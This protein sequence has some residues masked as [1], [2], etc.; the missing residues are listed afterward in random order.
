MSDLEFAK[1]DPL[2]FLGVSRAAEESPA[3]LQQLSAG[4]DSKRLPGISL[5]VEGSS[6]I[7]PYSMEN[8]P[9]GMQSIVADM[10]PAT[11]SDFV[12]SDL[13]PVLVEASDI[14]AV[15]AHVTDLGGSAEQI[16]KTVLRARIPRRRLAEMAED[17]A[18]T[19]I[20]SSRELESHCDLAHGSSRL[21]QARANG[22]PSQGEGVLIGIVDT[23]IDT[24]H[25]AFKKGG[26]TR[27]VRYIDQEQGVEYSRNDI[28]NGLAAASPD[29]VGHGTHVAGICAGN[30]AGSSKA[31]YAGVAPQA[32]I[33][34]VKTT[35][36][37][38]DVALGVKQIFD[39]ADELNQPCVVNLS[40]GGHFGAHDGTSVHERAIDA[41]S[42][43]GRLVV[44][45]A[46]N[47]GRSDLHAGT[48]LA[49]GNVTPVRWVADFELRPRI[50][51]NTLLGL[52]AVQVWHQHEDDI[53]IRLRS[54]NGEFFE[55]P[56]GGEKQFDRGVFVA[57]C[58]HQRAAHSQDHATTFQVI[59]SAQ[60]QWLT[61]WSVVVEE[62]RDNG[63]QGVQVG[64]VHAWILRRDMGRFTRGQT[65][66][67]LI[68]M[69]GT[70]FSAITVASYGTRNGWKSADPNQPDVSLDAVNVE[71]ISYFSSP[72]PSRDGDTKPEIA[73]PGQWLI[74]ALSSKATTEEIPKWLRSP[75]GKYTAMQGTSMSAP[76]TAGALALLLENEPTIDPGEAK[77]RLIKSARQD[78]FTAPCWNQRWGYGKLNIERLLQME[79]IW[80]PA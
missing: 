5:M 22:L 54:P 23:G 56:Q 38:D 60:P 49:S 70:A 69:P 57:T 39:V 13:V 26:Q 11:A 59:A 6:V 36:N 44:V 68:G 77:R 10:A 66:S 15:S 45:S 20:E 32:D 47:E 19:Y 40:L 80:H 78:S 76:Y 65:R 24:D 42:G 34:M 74:S 52:L 63:R 14:K 71:D 27:I 25:P 53:R 1:L 7:A 61:G 72:G 31:I 35:F 50:V 12:D 8:M 73:A 30:G 48:N 46:G 33:A 3:D 62:D 41:L 58:S 17:E 21:V 37:S 67:H 64:S 55:A 2:L 51:Q 75:N 9:L 29:I 43:P 18:V 79:P 28:D 16:T 4:A